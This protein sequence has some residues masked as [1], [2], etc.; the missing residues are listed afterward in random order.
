MRLVQD[1][2]ARLV[3][4]HQPSTTILF[5]KLGGILGK[6][7]RGHHVGVECIFGLF[8]CHSGLF[9]L[10]GEFVFN[11]LTN[12]VPWKNANWLILP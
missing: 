11:L 12:R 1:H 4:R 6:Q 9:G 7:T 10:G 5:R 8:V 3:R 2:I